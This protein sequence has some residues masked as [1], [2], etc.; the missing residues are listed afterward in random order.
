MKVN[1]IEPR[2]YRVNWT[3]RDGQI[4]SVELWERSAVLELVGVLHE[5]G[6]D[7]VYTIDLRTGEVL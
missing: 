3:D 2:N 4:G 1:D 7:S 5:I 6:C